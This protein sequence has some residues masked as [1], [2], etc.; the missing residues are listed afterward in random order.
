MRKVGDEDSIDGMNDD[1]ISVNSDANSDN[2]SEDDLLNRCDPFIEL[3]KSQS[4]QDYKTNSG[5]YDEVASRSKSYSEGGFIEESGN[6]S[7]VE[8]SVEESEEEEKK[9]GRKEK[10]KW[11]TIQKKFL[12]I[13]Q[14]MST[15][16]FC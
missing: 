7:S 12:T 15:V 4:E 14:L 8:G 6:N 13:T 16:L 5:E 11:L 1:E 2:D 10:M 3:Y 9:G